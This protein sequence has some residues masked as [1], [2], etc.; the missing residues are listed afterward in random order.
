MNKKT[1]K[2]SVGVVLREA[3]NNFI[4]NGN[5]DELEFR[6]WLG[7]RKNYYLARFENTIVAQ[8]PESSM[9][10]IL[11]LQE[12]VDKVKTLAF[13]QPAILQPEQEIDTNAG[14]SDNG[15]KDIQ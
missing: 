15:H 5:P 7:E 10:V 9:D 4:A 11:M 13:P 2:N 8:Q 6:L 3:L 14:I 1:Y 12:E